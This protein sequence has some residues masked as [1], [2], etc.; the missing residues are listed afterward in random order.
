MTGLRYV[1]R[2]G[3]DHEKPCSGCGKRAARPSR[4]SPRRSRARGSHDGLHAGQTG[5]RRAPGR[6]PVE[7]R[8][9]HECPGLR[10]TFALREKRRAHAQQ[11]ERRA[12]DSARPYAASPA[13]G[14]IHPERP[15]LRDLARRRRRYRS[16][17]APPGDPWPGQAAAAVY[18]RRARALSDGVA[19]DLCRMRRQQ[20]AAVFPRA[21]PGERAGAARAGVLRGMDRGGALHPA[22]GNRGR[23]QG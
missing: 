10:R 12:P 16:G 4:L 18:P 20:C 15:S 9:G 2:A 22:R 8:A 21:H 6:R 14:H 19:H 13:P 3:R 1:A 23:P 17:E 11:P 7:Q 5:G